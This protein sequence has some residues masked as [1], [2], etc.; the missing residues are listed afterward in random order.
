MLPGSKS[1]IAYPFPRLKTGRFWHLIPNPG[2]ETRIDM[3]FSSMTKLREVCAGAKMDEDNSKGHS[4]FHIRSDQGY[5]GHE[6]AKR[7]QNRCPRVKGRAL[8]M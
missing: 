8:S 1:C 2:N 3:D 7:K 5:D 6:Y 4:N